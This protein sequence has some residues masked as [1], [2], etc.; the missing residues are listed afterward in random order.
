VLYA[1]ME[2]DLKRLLAYHSVENVGIILIGLG[3]AL[4]LRSLEYPAAAALAL[5]AGLYHVLNHAVF[6]ALLFL[7]AGAVQ[8]AAH[9]RD[10]ESLGGLIHRMPW[11][12]ATFLIGAAAI[13]ALPPLNGFVSEWLTFQAL[14]ALITAGPGPVVAIGAALTAG[15]LALTSGLAAFCFVKAFGVAFLGMPRS[16]SARDAREVNWSMRGA[17]GGLALLCFGLGLLP[18][19]IVQLLSPVTATLA[20]VAA[21]PALGLTPLRPLGPEGAFAP[22]P[23]FLLLLA[24]GALGLLLARLFGGPGSERIAPPWTC[25]ISAEPSMQY[26]AAALAKP[27]RIIFRALIRPYRVVELEPARGGGRGNLDPTYFVT[28]VRYEAG[29]RSVYERY[30]Y[31]PAVR[32]L[33][34]VAQRI[35]SFQSGGLRTYLA[36]IFA[37]LVVV[38]LFTR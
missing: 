7:G 15:L 21:N 20:G 6:K 35:R 1:L 32:S 10:L 36:Y 14:L 12:A 3:A 13:S 9:T 33:L 22:L 29:V 27:I 28:S 26:T 30:L 24:F 23:L 2:H 37:T 17:M 16:A 18:T 4:V 25:G 19:A 34:A 11:T 31:G 38:L 5:L 8:Q